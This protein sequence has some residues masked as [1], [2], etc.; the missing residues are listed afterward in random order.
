MI[1]PMLN[2]PAWAARPSD[3]VLRGKNSLGRLIWPS[4]ANYAWWLVACLQKNNGAK[5]LDGKETGG[6]LARATS[7]TVEVYRFLAIFL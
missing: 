5:Y 7:S 1:Y 3:S 4:V 6:S 2:H